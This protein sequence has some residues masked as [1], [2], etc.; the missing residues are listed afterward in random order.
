MKIALS[1]GIEAVIKA[2]STNKDESGVQKYACGALWSLA[3]ND[4]RL[5]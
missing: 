4:G 1:G 3:E 2:M 5:D